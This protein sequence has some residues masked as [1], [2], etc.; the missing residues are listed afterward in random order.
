MNA[1]SP[2]SISTFFTCPRQYEA[3][4]V[5]KEVAFSESDN[6]RFGTAVHAAI[7]KAL[8][9]EAHLPALLEAMSG[10]LDGMRALNAKAETKMAITVERT[11]CAF[12]DK[13]AYLRC[14]ADS[15]IDAGE[16]VI[17]VDWKTG[18]K[19]DHQIQHDV[20]RE[21]AAAHY[22]NARRIMTVFVYLFSGECDVQ[23]HERNLMPK[24]LYVQLVHI[25]N[26]HT[27]NEFHPKPSGL[28]KQWCDVLSCVHNGRR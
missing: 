19:R 25:H 13:A 10:L 3:K 22:P 9:G 26:A 14:I 18:K 4:Y 21:C 8:K 20:L 6:T 24:E 27:R 5:T 23:E 16:L 17:L 12:F 7:E 11:P 2:T 1:Q 28:C 15:V